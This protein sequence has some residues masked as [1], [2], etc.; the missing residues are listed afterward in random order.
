MFNSCCSDLIAFDGI[1]SE[2]I[3]SI[4]AAAANLLVRLSASFRFQAAAG[5][6]H[7][8]FGSCWRSA[9]VCSSSSR[10]S[11]IGLL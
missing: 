6:V 11:E 7:E 5:G 9:E 4:P 3:L 2:T 8:L 10:S 1:Q